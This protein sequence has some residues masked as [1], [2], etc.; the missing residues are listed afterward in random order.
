L[1]APGEDRYPEN[2]SAENR[3]YDRND[4]CSFH[5]TLRLSDSEAY[6]LSRHKR[7]GFGTASKACGGRSSS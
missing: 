1:L 2:Y 7:R 5:V 6:R 3:E 4:I